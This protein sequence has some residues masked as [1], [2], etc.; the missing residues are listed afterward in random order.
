MNR[1]K[2]LLAC[3]VLISLAV[4]AQDS[5]SLKKKLN[6]LTLG[7]SNGTFPYSWPKQLQLALPNAQVFNISKSGRTIGFVN[8]GDSSL[9]SLL[10]IKE[11]LKK[12]A[13]FTKDRPYDF[14]VIELGTNDAKSV[15]AEQQKQVPRNLQSLIQQI[16]SSPYESINKAK[17]I[18][19]SPP[20]YGD[21]AEAQVKY[22]GG[23]KRVKKMSKRFKKIAKRDGCF[24]VNGYKTQGLDMNKMSADGLHLDAEAS[25][26]LIAPVLKIITR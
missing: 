14:I 20:P 8:L 4:N 19:I 3:L 11:N 23:A 5:S 15:F 13:E 7:D 26:K 10:V 1:L 17:I 25:K 18:I 16:K 12:A 6:L 9:N 2:C 24:Y 21:K 22:K